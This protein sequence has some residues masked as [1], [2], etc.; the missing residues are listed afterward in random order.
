MTGR[1]LREEVMR[2]PNDRLEDEVIIRVGSA[3]TFLHKILIYK[4]NERKENQIV[5]R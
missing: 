1:E 4:K 5:L 3:W 2:I